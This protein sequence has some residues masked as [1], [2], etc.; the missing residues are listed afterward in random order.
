VRLVTW[1]VGPLVGFAGAVA[2]G[3]QLS[4][5]DY[6]YFYGTA[7]A[8]AVA[9]AYSLKRERSPRQSATSATLSLLVALTAV[10]LA[11]E[12]LVRLVFDFSDIG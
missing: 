8:P 5:V 2:T 6:S 1:V 10:A 9:L 11:V 4:N 3:W 7:L 12:L